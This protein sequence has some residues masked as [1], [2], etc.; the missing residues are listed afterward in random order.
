MNSQSATRTLWHASREEIERPTIEGRT[1]GDNH[2]NSGLGIYCATKPMDYI[3]G[4]GGFVH[5]LVL[6][7][8]SRILRMTI[9]ELNKMGQ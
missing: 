8:A 4:F 5:E 9:P 3:C 2:A 7:P 6:A 1:A